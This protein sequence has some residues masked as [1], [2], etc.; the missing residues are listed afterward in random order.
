[1]NRD[2]LLALYADATTTRNLAH[3]AYGIALQNRRRDGDTDHA[4]QTLLQANRVRDRIYTALLALAA[5]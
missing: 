3:K 4:Y 5:N 1:M 2:E